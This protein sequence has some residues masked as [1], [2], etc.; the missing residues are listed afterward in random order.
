MARYHVE[1]DLLTSG[2]VRAD[3]CV[4][5]QGQFPAGSGAAAGQ[6]RHHDSAVAVS[7]V[8]EAADASQAE[9]KAG[10]LI[11]AAVSRAGVTPLETLARRVVRWD[12][13]E[14]EARA[15]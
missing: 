8:V 2:L 7:V 6:S 5:L 4:S 1:V 10:G 3:A 14:T 11:A 15:S 13:F 9:R 12:L